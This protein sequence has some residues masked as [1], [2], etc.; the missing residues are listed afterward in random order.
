MKQIGLYLHQSSILVF[1]I[2]PDSGLAIADNFIMERWLC[3][4]YE[5]H[6]KLLFTTFRATIKTFY[7]IQ[8]AISHSVLLRLKNKFFWKNLDR[9]CTSMYYNKSA[10]K[11]CFECLIWH[12]KSIKRCIIFR[13]IS[14]VV[15][16]FQRNCQCNCWWSDIGAC[17]WKMSIHLM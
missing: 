6:R 13:K 3:K 1:T 2:F 9:S 4:C 10:L 8:W 14:G 5:Y 16:Y 11:L 7:Y 12:N 15:T 17:S